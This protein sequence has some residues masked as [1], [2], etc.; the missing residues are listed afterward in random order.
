MWPVLMTW[1]IATL[2]IT[3]IMVF[4][5]IFVA[6]FVIVAVYKNIWRADANPSLPSLR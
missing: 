3:S 2:V 5:V 4:V 6:F 1:D